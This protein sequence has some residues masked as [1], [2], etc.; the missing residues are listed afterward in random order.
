MYTYY[1]SE[2]AISQPHVSLCHL[3]TAVHLLMAQ[4]VPSQPGGA[5]GH[6]KRTNLL[7]LSPTQDEKFSSAA[8]LSLL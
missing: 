1:I 3:E 7:Y 8:S 5:F 4:K 6:P 2:S